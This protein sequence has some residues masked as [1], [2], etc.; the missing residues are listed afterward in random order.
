MST[1]TATETC[2]CGATFT[3]RS[4]WATDIKARTS[5]WRHEHRCS[6]PVPPGRCGEPSSI[7]GGGFKT[8]YCELLAGHEGWHRS[9]Q[10]EWGRPKW[11]TSA[12]G[13]SQANEHLIDGQD[14]R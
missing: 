6:Q 5:L 2:A 14:Q 4:Q 10:C 13:G 8:E 3:T 11:T 1:H 9:E 12:N 7:K